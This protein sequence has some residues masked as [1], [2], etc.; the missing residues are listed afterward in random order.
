M[1]GGTP[2]AVP[3][4]NPFVGVPGYR[5]EIWAIGVRNPYRWSFDRATGDL[6]LAD[7][8]QTAWEEI[9]V[10]P[11]ASPGGENYGWRL[12]E[13]TQCFIPAAGC[14]P[15][16]LVDPVYEY[17]H[18]P[19]CAI[20]G[21]YVY[22]G[23]ALPFAGKYFFAD[24]CSKKIAS[25]VVDGQNVT[26]FIDWTSSLQTDVGTISFI[27]GF[28]EDVDGEL[29]VVDRGVGIG[30]GDVYA[31]IDDGSVAVGEVPPP[32]AVALSEPAP[33]PF[34]TGT[35]LRISTKTRGTASAE[36]LDA[37]G[38]L[39]C[40]LS[41]DADGPGRHR[42]SW[43]GRDERGRAA[44]AGVYFLRVRVGSESATRSVRLVR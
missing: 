32:P 22:R 6:W 37:A 23:G 39:V 11:A 17:P 3:P 18:D 44:P 27:V 5:E 43:D 1:N 16:G 2:Y 35:S 24:Y 25:I 41:V 21:G 38:R 30:T 40:T 12:K 28:G 14:D 7:V 13:G 4:S 26:E 36:V 31:L 34:R 19:E 42:V 20:V 33:N 29:Y 8:G 15:G 10:Q 9:D